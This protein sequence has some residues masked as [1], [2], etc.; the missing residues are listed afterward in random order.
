MAGEGVTQGSTLYAGSVSQ[1]AIYRIMA[2]LGFKWGEHSRTEILVDG[3]PRQLTKAE[4]EGT[5]L[6]ANIKNPTSSDFDSATWQT[7][8]DGRQLSVVELSAL[9]NFDVQDWKN[10]FPEYQPSGL[11]VDLQANPK[12][13]DVV[14]DLSMNK[15]HQEVNV[16]N[17]AGAAGAGSWDG[18]ETLILADAD[19]TQ[20]ET[21]AVL[22]AA[23]IL[24]YVFDL[25]DAVGERIVDNPNLKIFCSYADA[26]LFDRAARATNDAEVIATMDG[27]RSITLTGGGSIPIVPMQGISKDF[28]FATVG[29]QSEDSNLVQGVWMEN[30]LETLKMYRFAEGDQTWRILFRASLGVQIVTGKDIWYLNNV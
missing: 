7:V 6:Q 11:N 20:V 15:I 23:N 3:K 4:D 19:A 2:G 22:T 30:D 17:S 21:P 27:V 25:R 5:A 29:S 13:Q 10:T 12:I 24:D 26:K 8:I 18:Y 14:F 28:M 9:K 1:A 16:K